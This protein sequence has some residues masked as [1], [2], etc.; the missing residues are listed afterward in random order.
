MLQNCRNCSS[1]SVCTSC[2]LGFSLLNSKCVSSGCASSV[3]NCLQ[4]SLISTTCTTCQSG[5]AESNG[6]CTVSCPAS[7]VF[8]PRI[9]MCTCPES[10]FVGKGGLCISCSVECKSCTILGCTSCDQGYY[11]S[12]SSCLTCSSNCLTCV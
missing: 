1:P 5:F 10:S 3:A 6:I 11:L 7:F 2:Q 4:C 12:G 8:D 9:G